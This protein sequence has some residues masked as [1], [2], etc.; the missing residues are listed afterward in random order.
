[1]EIRR[2]VERYWIEVSQRLRNP[3]K[4]PYLWNSEV[5]PL[6]RVI[7][8]MQV[9]IEQYI[10]NAPPTRREKM[11]ILGIEELEKGEGYMPLDR[12]SN[13]I[14]LGGVAVPFNS[15]TQEN[16]L[17]KCYLFGLCESHPFYLLESVS[18]AL[19]EL[20]PQDPLGQMR[21]ARFFSSLKPSIIRALQ[22]KPADELERIFE[23]KLRF[24]N[25]VI[26]P[27]EFLD[28]AMKYGRF[29]PYVRGSWR[30]VVREGIQLIKSSDTKIVRKSIDGEWSEIKF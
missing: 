1:M 12:F 7:K 16:L 26:E 23:R 8:E 10:R 4:P 21:I 6:E 18:D 20:T 9:E 15:Y 11:A 13:T 25:P 28:E 19:A 14:T 2:D 22:G 5:Y 29:N 30:A 3:R 27:Q 24:H 17:F